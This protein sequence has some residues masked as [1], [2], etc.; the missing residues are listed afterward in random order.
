MGIWLMEVCKNCG[1]PNKLVLDRSNATKLCRNCGFV[2]DSSVLDKGKD[3]RV[4]A[5]DNSQADSARASISTENWYDHSGTCIVS[6]KNSLLMRTQTK[7]HHVTTERDLMTA[8]TELRLVS[9]AFALSEAILERCKSIIRHL[10]KLN[11]LKRRASTIYILAI[12]FIAC[13]CEKMDRSLYEMTRYDRSI[14]EK[15]LGRAIARIRLILPKEMH[16]KSVSAKELA[17]RLCSKFKLSPTFADAV[18]FVCEMS[19]RFSGRVRRT[20]SL[21]AGAIYFCATLKR[22][23]FDLRELSVRTGAGESTIRTVAR[24]IESHIT[25]TASAHLSEIL[26]Q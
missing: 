13:R 14:T 3:W 9:E 4:F 19:E 26:S 12:V 5:D 24:E 21:A 10:H 17:V 8:M 22:V 25:P 11:N 18:H 23:P 6:N 16:P 1:Q 7:L 15:D 2:S 20:N